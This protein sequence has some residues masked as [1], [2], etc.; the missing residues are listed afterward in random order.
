MKHA[1]KFILALALASCGQVQELA[2]V[3]CHMQSPVNI[4]PGKGIGSTHQVLVHYES[5]KERVANLG[6]TV[7]VEYDS[8]SYVNY[9][10]VNYQFQQFHFH[11]PSEHMVAGT[12][13]DMEMHIVHTYEREGAETPEY[14]VIGVLFMEGDE[15]EFLSTFLDAI[16]EKE[17]DVF[18]SDKKRV[19]AAE[20][21][22]EKLEDFFNYRGSLTTPPYTETVNW[23]VL[24]DARTASAEQIEVMR[25]TEGNNARRVQFLY[26]RVIESVN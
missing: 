12:A 21:I 14:L 4:V 11:T 20:M 3:N 17:G 25:A 7:E 8:G 9:D 24:R 13:Y 1:D 18:E 16:P 2:T 19:N 6:H 23:I 26:D 5:S 10:G 22:P 15:S